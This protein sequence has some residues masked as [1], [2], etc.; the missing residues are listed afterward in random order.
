MKSW[1][2]LH[3]KKAWDQIFNKKLHKQTSLTL[4]VYIP[5]SYFIHFQESLCWFISSKGILHSQ[6]LKC[7]F[8]MVFT[9]EG[10]TF[11]VPLCS[12]A[13]GYG[14]GRRFQHINGLE[15]GKVKWDLYCCFLAHS[16]TPQSRAAISHGSLLK[17]GV[18]SRL[19]LSF[20]GIPGPVSCF[21]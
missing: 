13:V 19:V 10:A 21:F 11:L 4:H 12:Q 9:W 17:L 20:F 6:P 7:Q 2:D 1:L 8:W 14:R 16:P 18:I 5:V 15:A 3:P